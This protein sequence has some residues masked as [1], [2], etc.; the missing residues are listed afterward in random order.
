MPR[1]CRPAESTGTS[2]L[3]TWVGQLWSGR[4]P[5]GIVLLYHSV[6]D[7]SSDP[8]LLSVTPHRFAAHMAW[9]ASRYRVVSL[10][11][12]VAGVRQE[13][14][15]D[16]KLVAV[17]FDD[18]YEDNLTYAKPVLEQYR[19]PATVFVATGLLEE[20]QE[21][22]WD[23]L[24]RIFLQPTTLP[25]ICRVPIE[26]A[27]YERDLGRVASYGEDEFLRHRRWSVIDKGNP[28]ARHAIYRELCMMM[29]PMT[30][31]KRMRV[32]E[33]IRAWSGM[34]DSARLPYRCLTSA[35][36]KELGS[37]SLVEIGAHSVSHTVL[38]TLPLDEQ[39]K[40]IC[41]S[42]DHLEQ[43]VGR[44]VTAFAY[45]YGAKADYGNETTELLR[46]A[47]FAVGCSNFPGVIKRRHDVFQLP[48]FIVRD[49]EQDIF[50]ESLDCWFAGKPEKSLHGT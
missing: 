28:T 29:R 5:K 2:A 14:L 24:E 47:G 48:R 17:T 16:E 31:R 26:E 32:L 37:G 20:N 38:S 25:Q 21:F 45:P 10:H 13:Q 42:R 40:E 8:Q 12:L 6:R 19:V 35:Q 22:W 18:G 3:R 46:E 33:A 11:E 27:M 15:Q 34:G 41:E 36:V 4:G 43:I 44:R 50:A 23:E 9:L 1:E 7:A 30:P 49:W 39:R